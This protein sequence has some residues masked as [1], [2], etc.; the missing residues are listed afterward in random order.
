VSL[1]ERLAE[2]ALDAADLT[3]NPEVERICN[4][5]AEQALYGNRSDDDLRFLG[6]TLTIHTRSKR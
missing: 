1:A 6:G 3:T 5:I 2:R 4:Y